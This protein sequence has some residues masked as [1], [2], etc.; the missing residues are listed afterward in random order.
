MTIPICDLIACVN[1]SITNVTTCELTLLQ[2]SSVSKDFDRSWVKSV[3]DVASLPDATLNKGRMIYVQSVCGYRISDGVSWS[4]DFT[5]IIQDFALWAWG[6]NASGQ[7]GS[8]TTTNTSS[9]V[10]VVGGFS[11]WCQISPGHRHTIAVRTNGSSWTWGCNASGQL[12]D[13]STTSKSSPGSV[14]GGFSD[15]CQVSAGY[16]HSLGLRTGG[17]AWAWGSNQN[18]RLGDGTS[19]SKSSPVSVV[20]GFSDWCQLSAGSSWSVGLS[21]TGRAWSWGTNAGGQLGDNTTTNRSSP[22]SVVPDTAIWCKVS[23]GN[24][25]NVAIRDDASTWAWGEN[26][27]G[28]LGDNTT[29][30]RSSPVVVTGG[31]SDWSQ[32]SAGRYHN[33]ALRT[34]GSV[35]SWGEN[36]SGKLGDNTTAN[37]SSPVSV[38]GGFTNWCQVSA[39]DSHSVAVRTS[40]TAWAWGFN[41]F[42]RLGDLTT[43]P[44]SSPVSIVGGFSD[45]CDV[46]AGNCHTVGLNATRGFV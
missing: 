19:T 20:G 7:L 28:Q 18:G 12:G 25:H 43:L 22:V 27:R 15:W 4:N 16:C 6:G 5:S 17:S 30:D 21:T 40:G 14:V 3:Y 29:T 9:P 42:G 8:N 26:S 41:Q 13:N 36:L 32:A 38:V 23:G 46:R 35:W 37:T 33:V 10:S 2:M 24:R 34:N 44:K 11:D 31:F 39:G 1:T 45:W